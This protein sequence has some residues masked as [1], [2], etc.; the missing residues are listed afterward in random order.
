MK[1]SYSNFTVFYVDNIYELKHNLL[2]CKHFDAQK[3]GINIW[4]K[5]EQIFQSFN[6]SFS[7][8]PI[9]TDQGANMIKALSLTDEARFPCLA[10]HLHQSY[11]QLLILLR[12]HGE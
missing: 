9:T 1:R 3:T 8:T 2:R 6:L 11:E 10:H 5:I 4:H 7:K 12:E